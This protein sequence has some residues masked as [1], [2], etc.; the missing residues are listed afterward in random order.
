MKISFLNTSLRL[1]TVFYATAIVIIDFFLTADLMI[2]I[3]HPWKCLKYFVTQ[4]IFKRIDNE[5]CTWQ[6]KMQK[7]N[8][9]THK[10]SVYLVVKKNENWLDRNRLV[11]WIPFH[12][13]IVSM[14]V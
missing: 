5:R 4:A 2:W 14:K 7:R 13:L 10:P 12:I 1:F 3:P 9:H 11:V 6:E 8:T